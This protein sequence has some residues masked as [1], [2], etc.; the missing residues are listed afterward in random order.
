MASGVSDT[1]A[2]RGNRHEGGRT[3]ASADINSDFFLPVQDLE[4]RMVKEL[5][6]RPSLEGSHSGS[7]PCGSGPEAFR[8]GELLVE[9][10]L[11]EALRAP[12]C[13][14]PD[15]VEKKWKVLIDRIRT[16]MSRSM[17]V[18]IRGWTPELNLKFS[19]M[20]M[21]L[22]FGDLGMRSQWADGCRVAASR[23][24]KGGM[25]EHH[26]ITTMSEFIKLAEDPTV[27][28]NF[29]DGKDVNM[30]GP[31]WAKPLLHSSIAWEHTM[32]LR[33]LKQAASKDKDPEVEFQQSPPEV[34]RS[35]TWT[36]L[37]W[38]LVT[39]AGYLTLAHFD[40]C[41]LGTYVIGNVGAK[42]WAVIR[43]KRNVCPSRLKELQKCLE[44]AA[45]LS[46]EG[47]FSNADIATVCLEEGDV[48]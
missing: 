4:T 18:V 3:Y 13:E 10:E 34:I 48:M 23:D 44:N 1:S 45:D 27:C 25:G 46:P 33:F 5:A 19:Q 6:S 7:E 21:A 14:D 15:A 47:E 42:L 28:G 24:R 17:S 20:S 43:A 38:R 29:L 41:G 32:H 9:I 30:G 12:G 35:G 31:M 22:Q 39:H 37:A 11:D 8:V 26:R 36:S 2:I 16:Y 40:C